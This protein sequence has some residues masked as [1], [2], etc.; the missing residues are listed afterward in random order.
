MAA[1]DGAVPLVPARMLNEFVYCPRLAILEWVDGEFAH[2]ADTV[3]GAVRHATVDRPG[4][5]VRLR[6]QGGD[7]A[8]PGPGA[9]VKQ[10]RS[11]ELSDAGLGLVAKIDLVEIEGDRVQPV[12]V[13]KAKR[14]HV[15]KGAYEPERVQVCAQG[16][17]LRAHGY[18]CESGVIYFAGSNE[19]VEVP[20]DDELVALTRAK[21]AEL[22]ETAAAGVLPPP[23]VDS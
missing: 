14:P 20:F 19:R 11:V 16:L 5:R 3:E 12:D 7:D 1:T 10:I 4:Y 8:T 13:K 15:E 2:S 9:F 18:A 21:L 22:R 23:L 6:K 17:L